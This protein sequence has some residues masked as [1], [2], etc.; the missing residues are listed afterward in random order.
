M[1]KFKELNIGDTFDFIGPDRSNSFF[2]R[3]TKTS[4]RKYQWDNPVRCSLSPSEHLET[5]VGTVN[6]EVFHV[7]EDE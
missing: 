4:E 7:N 1:T 3:C 6:V 2:N 5:R